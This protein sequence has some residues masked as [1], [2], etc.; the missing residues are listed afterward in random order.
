M[1]CSLPE[2]GFEVDSARH[3]PTS[4]PHSFTTQPP[5]SASAS[6]ALT[7]SHTASPGLTHA[8]AS[9]ASGK[10]RLD[11]FPAAL[12]EGSTS[13]ENEDTVTPDS[14]EKRL[15][16]TNL[17]SGISAVTAES[18]EES[19]AS[20]PN[21]ATAT[22]TAP[23][24]GYEVFLDIAAAEYEEASG[25]EVGTAVQVL[26]ADV[27]ILEF[28]QKL[29]NLS[30]VK[31]GRDK[32]NVTFQEV[33]A[34]YTIPEEELK[35]SPTPQIAE[36]LSSLEN[37]SVAPI[38]IEEAT[39][40]TDG[41]QNVFSTASV[42]GET[43]YLLEE[44][45]HIAASGMADVAIGRSLEDK[46]EAVAPTVDFEREANV[47]SIV[48]GV[49][50]DFAAQADVL[51]SIKQKEEYEAPPTHDNVEVVSSLKEEVG[52]TPN[53]EGESRFVPIVP[54]HPTL[55]T[56]T[57]VSKFNAN[58]VPTLEDETAVMST[59]AWEESDNVA[60]ADGERNFTAS[61]DEEANIASIID[62]KPT[63]TQDEH[64]PAQTPEDDLNVMPTSAPGEEANIIP[65]SSAPTSNLRVWTTTTGPST[66]FNNPDS[67]RKFPS[68]TT[69]ASPDPSSNTKPTMRAS[70][71]TLTSTTHWSKRAWSP[72]TPAT[73]APHR[74]AEAHKVTTFMPPV[75]HG[76][77]DVE[78]SL[79]HSPNLLILP[80]EGA[81]VGGT[82]KSSGNVKATFISLTLL[83]LL[84]DAVM[85]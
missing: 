2:K 77:A 79:T 73:M 40:V 75:D 57:L 26:G 62:E 1:L 52:I 15:N 81:A 27:K 82:G 25:H 35:I 34:V 10:V 29:V 17:Y 19:N 39:T 6:I 67:S 3:L 20:L 8:S 70:T 55:E 45:A 5:P 58:V 24:P 46:E 21:N 14:E 64:G 13:A 23:T 59:V 4:P 63:T 61:L 66:P 53:A 48:E 12:Q 43:L 51:L 68:V 37:D 83:N 9:N 18:L 76:V 84:L 11:A 60:S 71:K 56:V 16:L 41:E 85:Y 50:P 54:I 30:D 80:N 38:H 42:E 31:E 49:S 74:T 28:P 47:S 22:D 78:F 7:D 44:D 36:A 72:T 33:V 32:L 69:R 65:T